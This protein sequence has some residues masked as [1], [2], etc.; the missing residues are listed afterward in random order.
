VP[1]ETGSG[2]LWRAGRRRAS[3]CCRWCPSR[4]RGGTPTKGC[5][6]QTGPGE[7]RAVHT[8]TKENNLLVDHHSRDLGK[9]AGHHGHPRPRRLQARRP[10]PCECSKGEAGTGHRSRAAQGT[11]HAPFVRYARGSLRHLPGCAG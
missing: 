10:T 2:R 1:A 6:W 4:L 8:I 7:P 3:C 9:F 5:Q 11:Y